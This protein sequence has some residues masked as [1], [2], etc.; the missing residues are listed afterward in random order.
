MTNATFS[1]ANVIFFSGGD[2]IFDCE[3]IA[4]ITYP[5]SQK[6]SHSKKCN[7]CH[8]K[9]NIRHGFSCMS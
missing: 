5:G 9:C 4:L 6:L 2:Y 1:V 7:L 3:T 8:Q